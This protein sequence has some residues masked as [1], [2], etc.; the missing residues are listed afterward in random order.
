MA[1]E[2]FTVRMKLNTFEKCLSNSQHHIRGVFYALKRRKRKM[3]PSKF[4]LLHMANFN[5]EAQA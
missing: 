4:H 5:L 1:T 2:L 3:G